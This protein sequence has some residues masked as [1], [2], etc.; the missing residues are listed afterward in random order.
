MNWK[1]FVAQRIYRSK[2]GEKEISKPAVRIATAGI[3]V[4]LAVMILAVAVVVGFKHQVRDKVTG[5]S[6]DILITNFDKQKS[7]ETVPVVASDSL[8]RELHAI[9]G[10]EYAQRYSTKPGMIMTDDN[11][12]GMVLKGVDQ[13]YNLTYL[14]NHLLE[15]EIPSFTD[16]VSTNQTLISKTIAD[17][18]NIGVGEKLY[19]YY[20]E[21]DKVRARRLLVTGIY[22]T[23]FTL[24]DEQFL[25][26]DLYTVNRLNNW[27]SDQVSGIEIEIADYGMLESVKE[28][29]R[30]QI[31]MKTDKYGHI[32]YT[33]TVEE[34][35]PQIFAWLELLDMNVWVILILMIGVA[36]FTMISGLLIIILE[37]TNMIGV[38]KAMGADNLSIRK[39]FLSLSVFLIGKGML[40]GNAI[41]LVFI[42]VQSQYSL[43]KLDPTIYYIEKVPVEFNIGLW[44]LLNICTLIVSVLMLV[45]PSYLIAHIHP[46]KSI[47]FE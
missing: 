47:R 34:A 2:E 22:Q 12:L 18:L 33:K 14:T 9:S 37:R 41:G 29:I 3:A 6:T 21:G 20:L 23:N 17:K 26:T 24:F 28:N 38:L 39:I 13:G 25:I 44:L 30:S 46:A 10:V 5:L 8:L 16:T 19:T 45:G 42:F 35:Y 31:D 7:Y 27:E 11:F 36:G 32:Y 43:F 4:G 40:W 15:G 1:L